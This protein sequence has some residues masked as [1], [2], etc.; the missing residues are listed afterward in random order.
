MDRESVIFNVCMGNG[1]HCSW[2]MG[3]ENDNKQCMTLIKQTRI[4]ICSLYL[5]VMHFKHWLVTSSIFYIL[6]HIFTNGIALLCIEVSWGHNVGLLRYA[7][8]GQTSAWLSAAIMLIY[9]ENSIV[10]FTSRNTD[11]TLPQLNKF[12]VGRSITHRFL[13]DWWVRLLFYTNYA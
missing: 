7:T 1:L 12:K 8:I 4:C 5:Y 3:I 10:L 9:Y 6:S 13:C 2:S 11:V